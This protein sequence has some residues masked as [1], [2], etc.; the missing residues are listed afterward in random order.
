MVK[1]TTTAKM[2]GSRRFVR[3]VKVIWRAPAPWGS[4]MRPV[5]S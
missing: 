4:P 5:S 1:T 2:A 3:A